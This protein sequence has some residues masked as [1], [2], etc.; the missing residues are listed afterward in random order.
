MQQPHVGSHV[1]DLQDKCSVVN[2]LQCGIVQKGKPTWRSVAYSTLG[3]SCGV[4]SWPLQTTIK[5]TVLVNRI[6]ISFVL[7]HVPCALERTFHRGSLTKD[8][9]LLTS[10]MKMLTGY[11]SIVLFLLVA[12]FARFCLN[13][14]LL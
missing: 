5:W 7:H 12:C 2:C 14:M 3:D 11:F 9:R 8:C 13:F 10:T 6:W 4:R 1:V